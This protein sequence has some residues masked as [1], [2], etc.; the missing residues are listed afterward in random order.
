[1]DMNERKQGFHRSR[2][3]KAAFASEGHRGN[4]VTGRRRTE[5]YCLLSFLED[6]LT[7]TQP[8]SKPPQRGE[9]CGLSQSPAR[10]PVAPHWAGLSVLCPP[11]G[12]STLRQPHS[13]SLP[14]LQTP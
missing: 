8:T 14:R 13:R 1:M 10:R 9:A 6:D 4:G 3:S 7:R 2:R 5:G 12:T 11:V